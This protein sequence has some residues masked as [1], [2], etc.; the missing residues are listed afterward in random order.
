MMVDWMRSSYPTI[1][2]D[3]PRCVS[4]L[5]IRCRSLPLCSLSPTARSL[6]HSSVGLLPRR[7]QQGG[8]GRGKVRCSAM[9]THTH[10]HSSVVCCLSHPT[11][12]HHIRHVS[13]SVSLSLAPQTRSLV[14]PRRQGVRERRVSNDQSCPLSLCVARVL[15]SVCG[16]DRVTNPKM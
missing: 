3:T 15:P 2:H 9:E 16:V 4:P 7:G 8:T 14:Q 1:R 5:A 11:A 10:T 6:T 13:L 12:S